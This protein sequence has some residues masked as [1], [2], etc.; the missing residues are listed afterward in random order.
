VDAYFELRNAK[1][2]TQP[3][4]VTD[5][6]GK[7]PL[8]LSEAKS[9][10]LFRLTEAGY[11]QFRLANGRRDEVGVN[12]DP[13]ESNLDVIPD[14]VL[15]LWQGKR[16]QSSQAATAPGAATPRKIPQTL[17]WYVMLLVLASA[18]AESG[19]AS[20]YLGTQREE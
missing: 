18:L 19:L 17:W 12:P 20:R 2:Q 5:P 6:A 9:A 8:S 1:D 10:Q 7:R 4:E 13:K 3:V 11:Y 16:D 15:A 14:D